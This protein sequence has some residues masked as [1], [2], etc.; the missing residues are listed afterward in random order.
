VPPDGFN[1]AVPLFN[2]K[3][4]TFTE[5]MLDVNS[6]GWVIV[7]VCVLTH[8]FPSVTVTIYV[9]AINPLAVAVVLTGVVFQL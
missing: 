5:L 1:V 9:P 3:H 4:V 6:V 7:T 2:P 8:P